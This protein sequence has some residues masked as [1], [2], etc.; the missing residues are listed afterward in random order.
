M[1]LFFNSF[2]TLYKDIRVS[3]LFLALASLF[4]SLSEERKTT[5]FPSI[6]SPLFPQN[7]RGVPH[8][9]PFSNRD[10][11]GRHQLG[12]TTSYLYPHASQRK[13]KGSE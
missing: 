1:F 10:L 9:F 12:L 8:L 4:A 13:I 3:P 6:A 11:R 5:P 7:N 2:R